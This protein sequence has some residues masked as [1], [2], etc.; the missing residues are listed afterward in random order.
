MEQ[1]PVNANALG[2][3]TI[4]KSKQQIFTFTMN[5]IILSRI[6]ATPLYLECG[7]WQFGGLL[8]NVL[9]SVPTFLSDQN[10]R[11]RNRAANI[12]SCQIRCNKNKKCFLHYHHTF[13]LEPNTEVDSN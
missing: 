3:A 2:D 4:D 10:G 6:F 8:S 13:V 7:Q 9:L 12:T 11:K 5:G 1:F